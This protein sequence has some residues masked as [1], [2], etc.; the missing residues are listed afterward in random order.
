MHAETTQPADQIVCR[1]YSDSLRNALDPRQTLGEII[2]NGS[3]EAC[4]IIGK[5]ISLFVI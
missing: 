4:K 2:L 3:E 1:F 5:I